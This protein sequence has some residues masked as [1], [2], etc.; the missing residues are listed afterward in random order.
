MIV[1]PRH[2]AVF[3][4]IYK[5]GGSSLTRLLA[6]YTNPRF[7][8]GHNTCAGDGWQDAW[9]F[10]GLQHAW[11]TPESRLRLIERGLDPNHTI[12]AFVRDPYTWTLSIWNNFYRHA[13][14]S[15]G[16]E[17]AEK[18]PQADFKSYL[19]FLLSCG[20]DYWGRAPQT[21]FFGGSTLENVQIGYFEDLDKS[22]AKLFLHLNIDTPRSIPHDVEMSPKEREDF[23]SFYDTECVDIANHLYAPDFD[24]FGYQRISSLGADS[25]AG[26]SAAASLGR[27]LSLANTRVPDA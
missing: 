11:Y 26:N 18:F 10:E 25:M 9:H 12:F 5:T 17:F 23:Q 4:H 20:E 1:L 22:I 24:A 8:S 13:N 3:V 14:T 6:P 21:A 27:K 7:R 19:R 2:R 16:Q 15:L